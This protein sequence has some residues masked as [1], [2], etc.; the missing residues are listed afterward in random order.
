MLNTWLPINLFGF[1]KVVEFFRFAAAEEALLLLPTLQTSTPLL[2]AYVVWWWREGKKRML[3]D[4][5]LNLNRWHKEGMS[6]WS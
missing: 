1:N 4:H 6:V 2:L 3:G 5:T